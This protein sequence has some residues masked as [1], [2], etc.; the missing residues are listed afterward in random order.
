MESKTVQVKIDGDGEG[1]L[2]AVFSTLKVIDKDMDVTNPGAFKNGQEVILSDYNHGSIPRFGSAGRPPVGKGTIKEVGD[3]AIFTGKYFMDTAAGVEAYKT[4][5]AVGDLQEYSYHY[6][7]KDSALGKQDGKDV[8]FLKELDVYE[9]SPVYRGAG[10]GTHTI[11]IKQGYTDGMTDVLEA[12]RGIVRRTKDRQ[13]FRK[14]NGRDLSANDRKSIVELYA[15]A[16]EM[17]A[18]LV[19]EPQDDDPLSDGKLAGV[20]AQYEMQ[21][22]KTEGILCLEK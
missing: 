22:R 3:Q 18:L 8:R 7:V 9:V 5:K 16:E 15:L 11:D 14:D 4:T 12:M 19:S 20:I 1:S 2:T 17:N 6:E 10:E 21:K 13:A